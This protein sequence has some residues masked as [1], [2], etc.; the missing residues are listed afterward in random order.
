[1]FASDWVRGKAT[2]GLK[3]LGRAVTR[4][5][6]AVDRLLHPNDS[7][8]VQWPLVGKQSGM[9]HRVTTGGH[10]EPVRSRPTPPRWRRAVN[11]IAAWCHRLRL[12]WVEWTPGRSGRLFKGFVQKWIW[13][14]GFTGGLAV[15]VRQ[16]VVIARHV[17]GLGGLLGANAEM[18]GRLRDQPGLGAALKADDWLAGSLF[19]VLICAA[20]LVRGARH[21]KA[22]RRVTWVA[23][24]GVVTCAVGYF[25]ADLTENRR[26]RNYGSPA[27]LRGLGTA[28]D[29]KWAFLI[30][31][32]LLLAFLAPR[33]L[34]AGPNGEPVDKPSYA[35]RRMPDP[36]PNWQPNRGRGGIAVSGGG[37][38]SASFALGALQELRSQGLIRHARYV[39]SVSGGSY[40][41][42][43][44]TLANRANA[45]G[46]EP[47][48]AQGPEEQR[49]RRNL[50]YLFGN[51]P[52]F[53]AAMARLLVGLLV[54]LLL[55]IGII[56]AVV[57][58]VGWLIGTKQFH[59]ELRVNRTVVTRVGAVTVSA[60]GKGINE[61][62]CERTDRQTVGGCTP[63]ITAINIAAV[64][65]TVP[66]DDEHRDDLP[67][68]DLYEVHL[69]TTDLHVCVDVEIR[70]SGPSAQVRVP[71][72]ELSPGIVQVLGGTA[73]LLRQPELEFSSSVR[74]MMH[75][76]TSEVTQPTIVT[77]PSRD[78]EQCRCIV[79]ADLLRQLSFATQPKFALDNEIAVSAS[80]RTDLSRFRL[81]TAPVVHRESPMLQ[82]RPL[83]LTG[84]DWNGLFAVGAGALL[85]CIRVLQ[86]PKHWRAFDQLAALLVLAGTIVFL[87]RAGLPWLVDIYP[88]KVSQGLVSAPNGAVHVPLVGTING[89]LTAYVV[90]AISTLRRYAARP[91]KSVDTSRPIK[92]NARALTGKIMRFLQHVFV[93]AILIG[94]AAVSVISI[95]A[96]GAANGP[97]GHLPWLTRD[98]FG[99]AIPFPPDLTLWASIMVVLLLTRRRFEAGS[100]SLGPVYKRRL[101]WAFGLW[102]DGN[103]SFRLPLGDEQQQWEQFLC[104]DHTASRAERAGY[105]DGEERDGTELV[106]C[107][108]ANIL[109]EDRAPT[110]RRAVSFTVSRSLVGGPE[111]GWT[112]TRSYLERMGTR[113]RWDL[114][115]PAIVG[116]SGAAVSPAMGRQS[117]GPIGSVLAMLNVRLG[118]WLPNPQYVNGI[119]PNTKWDASPGWPWFICEV[120]RR[121]RIEAPYLY[122]TDGGHWENLGLVEALR[123][124]CMSIVCISA[125]GDGAYSMATL[126]EAIEI[127]R[128]DLGIDITMDVW[129]MRPRAGGEPAPTLL[130]G[131]Q[132]LQIDTVVPTV[133]RAATTGFAFGTIRYPGI[134]AEGTLLYIDAV[135]VDG[136]PIDVHAYAEKHSEFPDVST[137]DQFFDASDFEA[138]RALGAHLVTSALE[139]GPGQDFADRFAA[140][141]RSD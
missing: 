81:V 30:V 119:D 59:S 84:S 26:L 76:C 134:N 135:M 109:G 127:A 37:I 3:A 22:A 32:L 66:K 117:L 34:P 35:Q 88:R 36:R 118:A 12:G 110:G 82:R 83:D 104:A 55:V 70:P 17:D 42:G 95:L 94:L 73:K 5:S 101:F 41:T 16:L 7:G 2:T 57:R 120:L 107:C 25:V 105:F 92:A 140:C 24:F 51:R 79:A 44:I 139:T 141:T 103:R 80:D 50:N 56:F 23:R 130:S 131:R 39:T 71:I 122:V 114:N 45:V 93:A 29:L 54:N 77:D 1:M 87:L 137:G 64:T 138:Y 132:Y 10:V 14:A 63:L 48:L 28:T 33:P 128:T 68:G 123:R 65:G 129:P 4:V 90:L 78:A 125:A 133:G 21:T 40:V 97:M 61:H 52:V 74:S 75:N 15:M 18:I 9:E 38:R 108:A 102:R 86:R 121:Y 116:V 67:K 60:D 89:G 113:R 11:V 20:V 69:A 72:R 46:S 99:L 58:P 6:D 100:W 126:G 8:D 43:A 31:A 47:Y 124:G 98:L 136:L 112:S 111:V 27:D 19:V 53:F 115:I 49:L 62:L 91:N 13:W 85:F 106:L 96:L